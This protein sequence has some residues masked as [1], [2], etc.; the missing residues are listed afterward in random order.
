MEGIN[1]E[2]CTCGRPACRRVQGGYACLIPSCME[3]W[4]ETI[5]IALITRGVSEREPCPVDD[6][7]EGKVSLP[8]TCGPCHDFSRRDDLS[9]LDYGP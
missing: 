5:P 1:G 3:Q 7:R 2:T 8:L 9:P 6:I 4:G